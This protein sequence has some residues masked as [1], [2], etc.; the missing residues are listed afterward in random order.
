MPT[1]DRCG[2]PGYARYLHNAEER[3]IDVC[4]PCEPGNAHHLR[5]YHNATED[6]YPADDPAEVYD[7]WYG[8]GKPSRAK[9][10]ERDRASGAK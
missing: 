1:C 3:W 2:G 8:S 10:D 6:L 9:V 7:E 4:G 5:A